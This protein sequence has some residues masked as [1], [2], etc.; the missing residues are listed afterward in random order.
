MLESQKVFEDV[1]Y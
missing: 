1:F